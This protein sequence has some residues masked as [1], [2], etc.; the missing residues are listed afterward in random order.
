MARHR[1]PR[2]PKR[3]GRSFAPVRGVGSPSAALP[4]AETF[5]ERVR[6]RGLFPLPAALLAVPTFT[7]LWSAVGFL[8]GRPVSGWAFGFGLLAASG[9][10]LVGGGSWREG[11]K[12]VGWLWLAVLAILFVD[13]CFVAFSWWDAQAYHLPAADL[14]LRGW[15]PVFASTRPALLAATGADPAAFNAYHVAYLPR[16]GWI[17]SAVLAA[18]AGNL[19]LGDSLILMTGAALGGLAWRVTP[20]LFGADPRKRLFFASLAMFAPGVVASAFCGAQDGSLYALLMIFLLAASAYLRTGRT[21]WLGMAALAPVLGCNLKFTGLAWFVLSAG[22]F[23]APLAWGV[24]RGTRRG[25][26]LW[27]WV[28]ACA[29][30]F[31][32][33]LAVG[34]SPYL[35]NWV[36]H[37][38]PLYPEHTFSKTETPPAMTAD[39][40]LLNDDAAAMGYCGRVVN[41]YFSKWAAH[42]YYEWKLGKKPFRPVFHLDQVSGLG[43]GFRIIMCLTVVILCLTRRCST[44][45]LLIALI[46]TSFL[47][48]TRTMGYVRYVPQLW[49]FPVVVA[50]NAMTVNVPRSPVAGRALGV[51]VTAI[52]ATSTYIYLF[53]KA[54]HALGMSDYAL[55]ILQAMR[56]EPAPRAYVLALHDRYR[57]DGRCFAAWATLPPDLPSPHVF[58]YYYRT[59]LPECRTGDI[60]WQ[61]FAQMRELRALG[62][63]MFYLGEHLWYW[64][65]EPH[66]IR[67]PSMHDYA[68]PP[69][70]RLTPRNVLHLA[71]E[72]LPE[73]PGYLWRVS[74]F[75]ARQFRDHLAGGSGHGA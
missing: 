15:N 62:E 45:W 31:A 13:S 51:V 48:P 39:F 60:D 19:E 11:V 38:G 74:L 36:N 14:L 49:M 3:S 27:K 10:A 23:T 9:L 30:G 28:A 63:P 6:G 65:R 8:F 20:P 12:R 1:N 61:S 54:I 68:G 34:F 64:P 58:D 57:E 24:W 5:W 67:L 35:T 46:L 59:L 42:R 16:A 66:R 21:G 25:R 37:G 32:M 71:S 55:S 70:K 72:V 52:M 43:T 50:F 75:R 7:V 73:I 4:P 33:A 22:I 41:A 47:Q 18:V 2:T 40:D 26:T 56:D 69:R 17:W 29:A 53:V 44:P